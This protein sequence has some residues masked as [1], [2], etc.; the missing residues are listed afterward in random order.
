M[1]HKTSPTSKILLSLIVFSVLLISISSVSATLVSDQ[2]FTDATLGPVN[3][4]INVYTPGSLEY[5]LHNLFS[6]FTDKTSYG[7]GEQVEITSQINADTCFFNGLIIYY[8]KTNV[9]VPSHVDINGRASLVSGMTTLG[10]SND[11]SFDCS[12]GG[13]KNVIIESTIAFTT[14]NAGTYYFYQFFNPTTTAT[15]TYGWDIEK[16]SPIT[17][18]SSSATCTDT[19]WVFFSSINNGQI[20]SHKSNSCQPTTDY[21]TVC[22]SGWVVSGTTSATA[23]GIN[24]CAILSNNPPANNSG[25]GTGN[26]NGNTISVVKEPITL[27]SYYSSSSDSIF[28]KDIYCTTDSQCKT[29]NIGYMAECLSDEAV[30]QRLVQYYIDSCDANSGYLNDI[31]DFVTNGFPFIGKS[32]FCQEVSTIGISLEFKDNGAGICVARSTSS[33]GKIWE[34]LLGVVSSTGVPGQYVVIA[35]IVG[36]ISLLF[37]LASLLKR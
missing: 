12:D 5:I 37:L 29:S 25:S 7:S 15:S 21:R 34:N 18:S 30:Q 19:G 8:S 32:S 10:T 16:S 33:T 11:L 13:T 4:K 31:I 20:Q 35:T 17:V 1:K 3:L 9:A 26:S 22:N 14:N 23:T 24:T 2:T 27:S 6:I 28:N 36:L